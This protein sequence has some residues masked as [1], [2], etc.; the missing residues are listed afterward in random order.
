MNGRSIYVKVSMEWDSVIREKGEMSVSAASIIQLFHK[1]EKTCMVIVTCKEL[2]F[3]RN[4]QRM[5][6]DMSLWRNILK[7]D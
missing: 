2:P 5:F 3:G 6:L 7:A 1:Q 4:K